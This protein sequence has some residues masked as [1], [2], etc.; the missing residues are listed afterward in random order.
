MSALSL[1]QQ[2]VLSILSDSA[3]NRI[4]LFSVG[5]NRISGEALQS[6]GTSAIRVKGKQ[7]SLDNTLPRNVAVY[8]SKTDTMRISVDP[9]SSL[10]MKA[11]VLHECT[12]MVQDSEKMKM[13]VLDSETMAYIVQC[14]FFL[15]KAPPGMSAVAPAGAFGTILGRALDVARTLNSGESPSASDLASLQIAIK[16]AGLYT[17]T[18][19][20]LM[21]TNG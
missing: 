12:H 4:P 3:V 11:I 14:S 8:N 15:L 20:N 21:V 10:D 16:A 9:G 2:K 18:A 19:G 13:T 17:K 1:T 6:L 5:A 7:V